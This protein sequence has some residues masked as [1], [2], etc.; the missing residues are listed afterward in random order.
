MQ[1][2][3]RPGQRIEPFRG[4]SRTHATAVSVAVETRAITALTACAHTRSAFLFRRLLLHSALVTDGQEESPGRCH[5][6]ST[7]PDAC[8]R[9][10]ETTCRAPE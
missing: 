4:F 9:S 1:G 7:T 8:V 3:H 5:P 10:E 2:P 6:P